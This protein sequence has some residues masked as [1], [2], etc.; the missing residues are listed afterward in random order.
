MISDAALESVGPKA[1]SV[2]ERAFLDAK[3]VP[4]SFKVY[5]VSAK[6]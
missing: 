3:G 2:E 6:G 5:A 4:E 1:V